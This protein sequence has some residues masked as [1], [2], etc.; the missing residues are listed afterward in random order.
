MPMAATRWPRRRLPPCLGGRR[1]LR[2]RRSSAT[3]R[4]VLEDVLDGK[5][6]R[7]AARDQLRRRPHAATG[8]AAVDDARRP[9]ARREGGDACRVDLRDPRRHRA[10]R[11]R[12][13]AGARRRRVRDGRIARDRRVERRRRRELDAT[14]LL[15]AP[16]FIDIHSHSD[17]TLLVDPRALSAIHQGVTLEVVG[18]CGLGCF[19]I[20]RSAARA[21]A[22]STA[23]T[24]PSRSTW[25]TAAGLLRAARGRAA[26]R[27]TCSASCRTA[28]SGSRSSA[29][30]TGPATRRRARGDGA[31]RSRRR[32]SR[33]PGATR[34]GSSTRR[35]G[36]DRGRARAPLPR[37]ARPARRLYATHTRQPRRRRG[38]GG[39]GGDP[40]RRARGRDAAAGLAPDPAQRRGRGDGAAS[41][42]S[43]APRERRAR[44]RLRHAHA[45]VRHDVPAHAAAA[46]GARRAARPAVAALLRDPA[47]AR[48][49]C[50]ATE[51]ILSA[52]G[53][54]T[55][56]VLL[57]NAVWPEHARR[58]LASI[59]A[60]RGQ[61][62]LDAVYDLLLD[63]PPRP[64][65]A[66]GDDPLPHRARSSARRSRIRSACR[67]RTRRR[68]RPTA[69]SPA[70]VFHGAY[71]WAAWFYRF[72]V[73]ESGC[74][75]RRRRCAG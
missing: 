17:Y 29:S 70:R 46:V 74:S 21:R 53:D 69:R 45:A 33:A 52:G 43:T 7:A 50:A 42:S 4:L 20:A 64:D 12:R 23:T 39:R 63:A 5:V 47:A 32:S 22:R 25:Q 51:S 66:D 16:G 19:P 36:R 44:R 10:R 60:E 1:R 58:D 11:H 62:P 27:S 37:V 18:N 55:R 48:R 15:V 2:A 13:G 40:R 31:A 68:S 38:R 26:R 14:G 56:I 3:R 9:A 57:D 49:G 61:D 41:R 28:S 75:R 34:P 71:T 72:M 35:S 8:R 30:P 59:A 54:W 24:T 73:R 65:A 6:S 67:A